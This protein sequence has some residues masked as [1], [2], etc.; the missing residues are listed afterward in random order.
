MV[1]AEVNNDYD[2]KFYLKEYI[3]ANGTQFGIKE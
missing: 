3:F 2:F 1:Y